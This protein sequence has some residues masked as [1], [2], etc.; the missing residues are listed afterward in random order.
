MNPNWGRML[1]LWN[2]I[3]HPALAE[4]PTEVNCDWQWSEL[5]QHTRAI[6]LGE[7]PRALQPIVQPIDD[8]NRNWK[9]GLLF[10]C[11]VGPGRLMVCSADIETD[12]AGR[13]V[14]RQLRQSLLDYM[15][16]PKFAP[17]TAV[18]AE[19]LGNLWFDSRIMKHLGASVQAD[20]ANAANL[21]DG[22]PNTFWAVG[23]PP[24]RPPTAL[25]PVALPPRGPRM[26]VVSFP[27]AVSINGLELMTR[28][29][30][31][32]H[33]GDIRGFTVDVSADGVAWS[34]IAEGELASTFV[35][36]LVRFGRSVAVRQVKLT[37]LSGFGT[38]PS[39]ALAELAVLY[40]G[41]KLAV[42][43]SGDVNYQRVRST[44]GDVI[45]GGPAVLPPARH[46]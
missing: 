43:D 21:I 19:A 35:P 16:G 20:G 23:L 2:D 3:H 13:P 28:Q 4:F 33:T 8:W 25:A 15:R 32:N 17:K 18:A 6:N 30:D 11:R 29:N 46:E 7:L 12:L 34:R 38:D 24:P 5:L 36:Q 39:T 42:D 22:D 40:T 45:E 41:P 14:A 1:G 44:S 10:E 37:A 27:S 26:I 31:R 9:L